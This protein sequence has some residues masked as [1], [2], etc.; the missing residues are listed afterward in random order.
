MG[1]GDDILAAGQAK[2]LG[3]PVQIGDGVATCMRNPLYKYIPYI[4]KH[5]KDWFIDYGGN[6]GYI[7]E[8]IRYGSGERIVFNMD[9]KAE[10]ALI[11]L[12]PI[13]NDYVIIE[14]HIK[15]GAPP[16]KQWPYYQSVVRGCDYRFLQ[17]NSD[18]LGVESVVTS[19]VTAARYIAGCKCYIGTEG[20]LHHLA[21]AFN[22]PAV[23]LFGAYSHPKVTG[24]DFH[25]NIWRDVPKELGERCKKG[26]AMATIPPEEV[27]EALHDCYRGN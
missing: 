18:S 14:P 10:P 12:E 25:T 9:Y 20:F 23:V 15:P 19:I 17:F 4:S 1:L 21:A 22:K 7:K 26:R 11:E 2:L 13:E 8:V 27:I 24:Y 16:G 3:Y 5:A 6:R